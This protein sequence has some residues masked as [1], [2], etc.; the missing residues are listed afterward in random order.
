M[1]FWGMGLLG[2]L[3][4]ALDFEFSFLDYEVLCKTRNEASVLRKFYVITFL[5]LYTYTPTLHPPPPPH[6]HIFS[7]V[8]SELSKRKI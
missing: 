7:F 2:H 6:N 3:K 5:V 4:F 8:I 1:L